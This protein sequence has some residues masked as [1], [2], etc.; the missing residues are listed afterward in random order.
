MIIYEE[1]LSN[2]LEGVSLSKANKDLDSKKIALK[3]SI[4]RKKMKCPKGSTISFEIDKES[5]KVKAKC[6]PI[7][8]KKAFLMKNAAK[9]MKANPKL[10]KIRAKK[11]QATKQ[12][13]GTN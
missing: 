11:A 10:L 8:K 2:L 1:I 9:K 5:K 13:R 12:F 6:T 3:K 7:D 4:L